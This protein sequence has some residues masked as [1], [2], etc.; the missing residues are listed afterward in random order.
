M[1]YFSL[2]KTFEENKRYYLELTLKN[3]PDKGGSEE[4]FKEIKNYWDI[5]NTIFDNLPWIK[6]ELNLKTKIIKVPQPVYIEKKI[7]TEDVL[8]A[9][10]VLTKNINKLFKTINKD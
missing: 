10:T 8:K 7:V 4:I 2:N 9:A 5:Y 6:S 3:H 1:K